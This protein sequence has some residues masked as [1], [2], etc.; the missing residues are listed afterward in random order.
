MTSAT[1]LK[2]LLYIFFNFIILIMFLSMELPLFP[3]YVI[4]III[5][6]YYTGKIFVHICLNFKKNK[7]NNYIFFCVFVVVLFCLI[8]FILYAFLMSITE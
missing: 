8:A 5:Y 6:L 4:L 3:I 2:K 1:L 7:I